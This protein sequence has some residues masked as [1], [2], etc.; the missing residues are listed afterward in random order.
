MSAFDPLRT[1]GANVIVTAVTPHRLLAVTALCIAS[2]SSCS[3][4]TLPAVSRS[5]APVWIDH[6]TVGTNDL[7]AAMAEFEQL[8][9]VR[10]VLGGVHPGKGTR[11][12]VVSLGEDAFLE[13]YAPNPAEPRET[14]TVR[15]LQAL[16]KMKPVAWAL[17]TS[18]ESKLRSALASTPFNLE[19]PTPGARL[20]ASGMVLEWADF[21]FAD[22]D[23]PLLPFFIR[24]KQPSLH[25]SRTAPQGCR[26]LSVRLA[27][28]QPKILLAA[29]NAVRLQVTVKKAPE[30]KMEV[31]LACP[32]GNV[33]LD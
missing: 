24:W 5:G 18:E 29:I 12:A 27:D 2:L 22:V 17:A 21:G 6:I 8:T 28:P 4:E 7:D 3:T 16:R 1:L 14:E 32:R 25:S 9:G 20:T 33:V 30:R 13:L 31:R 11:N 26:L 19:S 10:P 15:S 23:H